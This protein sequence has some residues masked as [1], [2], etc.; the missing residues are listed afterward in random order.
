[1][2]RLSSHLD[3]PN[4]DDRDHSRELELHIR[5]RTQLAAD[6]R[7]VESVHAQINERS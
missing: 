1:M 6:K 2:S 3:I 5:S 4:H 7:K